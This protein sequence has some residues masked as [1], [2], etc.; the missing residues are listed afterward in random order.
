VKDFGIKYPVAVDNKLAIWRAFDNRYWPAQYLAD[1]KGRIRYHHFGEGGEERTEAA[2]RQLLTE[3]GAR[4]GAMAG[5]A[6]QS[7]A[8]AAADFAA[9]KSPETYLG[10]ARM[11]NFVSPGGARRDVATYTVPD[12][13]SLNQWGLT[14]RW[15]IGSQS[16]RLA[17][18][19]GTIRFRFEARDVHLVLGS[20]DGKPIRFQVTLDDRAPGTDHGGD[21][22]AA[23]NGTV[24]GHRL[25]QLIRQRDPKGEH[26]FEIRFLDPGVEAYA[27]TFG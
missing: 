16:A 6:D 21:I 24:T 22:D 15:V 26:V 11:K 12:A 27:F 2:I 8:R 19:G 17:A 5:P 13:L 18:P 25:Y 7:G 10:T 14:G 23:G 9:V 3:N 20:A 1:A 4:L